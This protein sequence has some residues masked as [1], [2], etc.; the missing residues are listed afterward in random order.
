MALSIFTTITNPG[1]RGD[2]YKDALNC[3]KDLADEVIVMNGGGQLTEYSGIKY[4]NH[5]WPEEF[6]WEFIG[7]QFTRGYKACTGDVVIRADLDYIFHEK[8]FDTIR[9]AAQTMLDNKLPAMSMWKY[10]FILPDRYNL[11]S[12]LVTMVNKRGFGDRIKFDSS[13]DL[14]QPSLDGEYI[15]PSDVPETRIAIW[16]Y[17]KILKT[18]EQIMNDQGR[19]ER[20]YNRRF[21]R[22]QISDNET[23]ES[24]YKG[25][26]QMQQGRFN[27]PQEHIA[28]DK[29]PKYVQETIKNLKPE[30]FGYSGFGEL[31]VNDYAKD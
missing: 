21:G 14:C 8:D 1:Q 6:S 22:Y 29:H 19:M 17:E 4:I 2:N 23:D 16:N 10:Q 15:N 13:G 26:L 20:A 25:W 27:K 28:L 12:R 18:K 5:K 3:Y 7:Q 31:G 9:E 24:A 11:K 30:Q